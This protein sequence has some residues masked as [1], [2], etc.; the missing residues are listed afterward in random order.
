MIL[1]SHQTYY[2]LGM[3]L[4]KF[5]LRGLTL[6]QF[7]RPNRYNTTSLD[8]S[9]R[10]KFREEFIFRK[11]QQETDECMKEKTYKLHRS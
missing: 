3:K 6:I 9:G 11:R 4:N 5:F 7:H 1:W 2:Q 10:K 8:K